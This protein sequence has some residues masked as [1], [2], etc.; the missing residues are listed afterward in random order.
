MAS[1]AVLVMNG[2]WPQGQ[3][4]LCKFR[5]VQ[6]KI[7]EKKQHP[8]HHHARGENS[9]VSAELSLRAQVAATPLTWPTGEAT[10]SCSISPR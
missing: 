9:Q 3:G 4:L 6:E 10:P 7:R 2:D 5:G 1:V 8:I